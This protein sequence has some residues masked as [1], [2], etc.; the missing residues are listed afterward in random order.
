M[1]NVDRVRELQA[2]FHGDYAVILRD[3]TKLSLSRSYRARVEP[4][5]GE[6]G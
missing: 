3:G 1:V 2:L 4:L 5:L 6:G